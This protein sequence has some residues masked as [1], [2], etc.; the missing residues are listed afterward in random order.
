MKLMIAVPVYGDVKLEFMKS[1]IA[2]VERMKD[3]GVRYEVR[4]K[5]GTLIHM[6]REQLAAEAINEGYTHILW[7]D[8][9]MQF[10]G[11]VFERLAETGKRFVSGIYCT[12]RLPVRRTIFRSMLPVV[13][14]ERIPEGNAPE[15]K[16]RVFEPA[17]HVFE[18]AGC[19]FACVL[20]E[21]SL[22]KE[23]LQKRGTLFTPT[24]EY[25]E[26]LAL[27]VRVHDI[28]EKMFARGDV[29]LGHAG[30]FVYWP[31]DAEALNAAAKTAAEKSAAAK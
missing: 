11:D 13:P 28:G 8:C 12:R 6:A 20:T 27:C 24:R 3:T 14:F 15:S 25:S 29:R 19:G 9:D 2:L 23:V 7:L 26:D 30:N 22:L 4:T 1:L 16:G 21:V 10:E 31:E 5:E 18:I 17:D